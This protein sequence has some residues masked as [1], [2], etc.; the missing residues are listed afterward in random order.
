MSRKLDECKTLVRGVS[1]N[2]RGGLRVAAHPRRAE[3][4]LTGARRGG[5]RTADGAGG[6]RAGAGRVPYVAE[7]EAVQ[8][9]PKLT[10]ADKFTPT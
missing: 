10:P 9:D 4:L 1:C 7:G 5:V 3:Q 8:V 6:A 2:A